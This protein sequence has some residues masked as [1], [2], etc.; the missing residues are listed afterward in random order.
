MNIGAQQTCKKGCCKNNQKLVIC[1]EI[2]NG[3]RDQGD[4]KINMTHQKKPF[5]NLII[6]DIKF[7][8]F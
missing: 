6:K 7:V 4:F 3:G 8:F 2:K 5:Y 1:H